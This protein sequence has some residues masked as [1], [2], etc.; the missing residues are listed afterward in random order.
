MDRIELST[1]IKFHRG[2][3]NKSI[4]QPLHSFD[5]LAVIVTFVLS[6]KLLRMRPVIT[7]V[8]CVEVLR[9]GLGLGICNA[10]NICNE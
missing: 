3:T 10:L 4:G 7:L 6:V 5:Y 2:P 9:R 8:F 1:A